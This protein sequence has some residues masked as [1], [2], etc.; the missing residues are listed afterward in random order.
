M[1]RFPVLVGIAALAIPSL[2]QAQP[3]PPTLELTYTTYAAGFT[4]LRLIADLTLTQEGYRVALAYQTVG[5]VGFFLP[6]HDN[7]SAVGSWHGKSA[8]PDEF[9]SEG[10]WGGRSYDV[11]LD[12]PEGAPEVQR[13]EPAET[14]RREPVPASLRQDTI[15]TASA[16]ALLL[17]RMIAG[18]G[19]ALSARVF[20][21]RRLMVLAAEGAG[22]DTLGP[23]VRSFFHGPA[24][25]CDITGRVLAGFLRTDGPAERQRVRHGAV[26]FAHPIAGLPLLPVRMTFDNRWFGVATMYLTDVTAGPRRLPAAPSALALAPTGTDPPPAPAG[27]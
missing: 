23:T 18:E 20:D 6:G 9:Q 16:M 13:L 19:C 17:H 26:W 22:T 11:V 3:L 12:Y 7:A 14:S 1:R 21:G 27:R 8:R 24:I 2:A 5:A 15:D 4:T 10:T 25:R